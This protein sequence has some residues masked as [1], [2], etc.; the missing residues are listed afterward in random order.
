MLPFIVLCEI[1]VIRGFKLYDNFYIPVP[2]TQ[3]FAVQFDGHEPH[4]AIEP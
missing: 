1:L 3:I 4:V 2:P